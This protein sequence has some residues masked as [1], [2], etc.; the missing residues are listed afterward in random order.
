MSMRSKVMKEIVNRNRHFFRLPLVFSFF[1]HN[2]WTRERISHLQTRPVV[3]PN[4]HFKLSFIKIGWVLRELSCTH[5]HTHDHP[6]S[7]LVWLINFIIIIIINWQLY[8]SILWASFRL[9]RLRSYLWLLTTN[10]KIKINQK[11]NDVNTIIVFERSSLYTL[12]L[13]AQ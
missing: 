7:P 13:T 5:T 1:S 6:I 3:C 10:Y 9:F 4:G 12:K 2:F 11:T 8:Y